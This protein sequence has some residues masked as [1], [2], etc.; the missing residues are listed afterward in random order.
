MQILAIE[1][2]QLAMPKGQEDLA[3]GFYCDALGFTEV[4]KPSNLAKRGGAWF[5][6]GSVNIHLGVEHE[7]RAAKKAHPAFLV[8][9]ID[10]LAERVRS[11]GFDVTIDE[12][13]PGFKRFYSNDPF[14]NRLEFM[15]A[16]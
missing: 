3:R 5:Q 16:A 8:S 7:F 2:V 9:N 12:N 1:H 13:L 14:G 11:A 6:V 15:E 10:D 4:P